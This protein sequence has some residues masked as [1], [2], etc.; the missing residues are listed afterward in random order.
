MSK[1]IALILLCI[2]YGVVIGLSL[3]SHG[4]TPPRKPF[5]ASPVLWLVMVE[6]LLVSAIAE[7]WWFQ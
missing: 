2:G 6:M 3:Y 1:W 4:K 7:L 5:D